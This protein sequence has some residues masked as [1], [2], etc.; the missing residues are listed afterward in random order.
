M[1]RRRAKIAERT[2]KKKA[3]SSQ[4]VGS[5]RCL[6]FHK[7]KAIKRMTGSRAADNG[8]RDVIIMMW[9]RH[10]CGSKKTK[11]IITS[12]YFGRKLHTLRKIDIYCMDYLHVMENMPIFASRNK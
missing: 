10:K 1:A 7:I 2:P 5:G 8:M 4:E 9:N 11:K 12:K 3:R 6:S